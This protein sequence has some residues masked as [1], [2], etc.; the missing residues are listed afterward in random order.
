MQWLAKPLLSRILS[1]NAEQAFAVE[2]RGI[3]PERFCV[4]GQELMARKI[5]RK[6]TE[7][8]IEIDVVD[9]EDPAG[10]QGGPGLVQFEIHVTFRMP[11]V[12]NEE[13]DLPEPAK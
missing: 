13:I 3:R 4:A 9:K 12:M 6:G 11:A 2:T 10:S 8:P 7:R 5:L 1:D